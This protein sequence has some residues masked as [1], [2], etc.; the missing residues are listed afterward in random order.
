[1]AE[2]PPKLRASIEAAEALRVGPN[3]QPPN[4]FILKIENLGDPVR[5][6]SGELCRLYLKGGLGPGPEALASHRPSRG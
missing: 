1:M 5:Q 2:E 6:P 3:P 4:Q